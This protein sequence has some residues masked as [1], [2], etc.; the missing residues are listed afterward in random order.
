MNAKLLDKFKFCLDSKQ[1]S[2]KAFPFELFVSYIT[3]KYAF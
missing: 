1:F 3:E 2:K